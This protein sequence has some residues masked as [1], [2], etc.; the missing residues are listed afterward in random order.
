MP[1]VFTITEPLVGLVPLVKVNVSPSASVAVTVPFTATSSLVVLASLLAIGA[2]L[3]GLTVMV[4]VATLLSELPS[5]A[6]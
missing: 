2:S 6:L 5:L 1:S 4:T 3:T